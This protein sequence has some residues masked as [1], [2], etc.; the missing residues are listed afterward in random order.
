MQSEAE[1]R[2]AILIADDDEALAGVIN[3]A[4][5]PEGYRSR[6]APT[7]EA[8][9]AA[10]DS[11]RWDLILLDTLGARPGAETRR[12]ILEVVRRASP[13]PV[14]VMTGWQEVATFAR[15]VPQVAAVLEKPFDLDL[16]LHQLA[17]LVPKRP[18]S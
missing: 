11:E 13:T 12:F 17:D 7:R 2:R 1:R 3:A 15:S 10:I 16:L 6:H 18:E 8:T 5:S 4:L 9:L 14:L